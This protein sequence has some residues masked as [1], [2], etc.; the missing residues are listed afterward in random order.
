MFVLVAIHQILVNLFVAIVVIRRVSVVMMRLWT[1]FPRFLHTAFRLRVRLRR[2][3]CRRSHVF[4]VFIIRLVFAKVQVLVP[5]R[6][7]AVEMVAKLVL[8]ALAVLFTFVMMH[9]RQGFV[10]P[11][12][13]L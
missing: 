7:V 5:I 2:G 1:L 13:S 12:A 10:H 9:V 4:V 3:F 8:V 6:I 11:R